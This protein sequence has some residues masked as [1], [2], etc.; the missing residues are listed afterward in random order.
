VTLYLVGIFIGLAFRVLPIKLGYAFAHVVGY[1]VFR[2]WDRGRTC[3]RENLR[4]VL[5]S[6]ASREEIDT[7][8]KTALRN[9]LKYLL[10][11]VC[12]P[13]VTPEEVMR[14]VSFEGWE[15]LGKSLEG[16]KGAILVGLHQGYWEITGGAVVLG[17]HR[18][19]VV[20]ESMPS[21]RLDRFMQ[22]RRRGMWMNVIPME[23]GVKEMLRALR[24]NEHLVLLIDIPN[25]DG[26]VE[27]RFG[28]ALTTMPRGAATLALKTGASVVPI[29][30]VRRPD[31]TLLTFFGECIHFQPSGSLTTDVQALT[32]AIMN[33]LEPYIMRYPEQ[34]YMFRR[35]WPGEAMTCCPS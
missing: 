25:S 31:N 34:Y 16:G 4:H 30:C 3:L 21:P 11:Y 9:Y 26:G 35:M 22:E 8:A 23:K 17:G 6:S 27:V 19:N 15:N 7:L 29:A 20:V 5:G 1:I 28:D 33:A 24:R 14:R 32:Q 12:Q 10:D 18:L 2:V 13:R